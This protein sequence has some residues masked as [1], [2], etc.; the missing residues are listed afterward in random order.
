M[1][2]RV[3]TNELQRYSFYVALTG[4]SPRDGCPVINI[5][6]RHGP[7]IHELPAMRSRRSWCGD[8]AERWRE[9]ERETVVESSMNKWLRSLSRSRTDSRTER[10][11][12]ARPTKE[13]YTYVVV[14]RLENYICSRKLLLM[15]GWD[16]D[17]WLGR[18]RKMNEEER[19]RP[20]NFYDTP[21]MCCVCIVYAQD[22]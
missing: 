8:G 9:R 17:G 20:C 15:L 18:W 1:S 5:N 22:A 16:D 3:D 6:L 2:M 11:A 7:A 10:Q 4:A 21:T 14:L 19:I 13:H 12:G